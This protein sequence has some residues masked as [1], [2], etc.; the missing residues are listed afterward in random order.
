VSA[1]D[2]GS[3][4][5]TPPAPRRRVRAPVV[6]AALF[7]LA[8]VAWAITIQQASGMGGA[9][10]AGTMGLG[11]AAFLV[12][13]TVMMAAMM[14]PSV[15]PVTSLYLRTV[16]ADA[17]GA[18]RTFR[19]SG[20]VIG[21]LVAWAAFGLVAYLLALGAERVIDAH[22]TWGPWI[23]AVLLGVA[24]IYQLTPLKD[25]CLRHCRSPLGFL[26]HFASYK[27]RVKDL[28]V[29][30][31]HGLYCVGCCWGLM[32]VLIAVGVMNLAWMAGL[33]VV[34]FIEKTWRYGKAFGIAF[35]IALIVL[36]LLVPSHPGLVPGLQPSS[37]MSPMGM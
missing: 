12:L 35:G 28:R 9:V 4:A 5:V 23:G 26:M 16:R 2:P 29:G 31:Y 8:A 25:R 10:G 11:L 17:T 19:V 32:V 34:I 36:A 6:W 27:G 24:G 22:P 30:A 14:L 20:L 3:A 1:I 33:A 7:A 18:V 21:Y 13:W 37:G 15:A